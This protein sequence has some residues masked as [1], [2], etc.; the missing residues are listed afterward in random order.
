MFDLL[1]MAIPPV[2]ATGSTTETEAV[3][4]AEAR[5]KPT[6]VIAPITPWVSVSFGLANLATIDAF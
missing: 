5:A 4:L 6:V 3:V 1:P 2:T